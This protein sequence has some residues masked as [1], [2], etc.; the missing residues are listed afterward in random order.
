MHNAS[1]PVSLP[2]DIPMAVFQM[3]PNEAVLWIGCTPP[4][5]KYYS[6]RS[7][8]ASR[9]VPT[10]MFIFGSLGDSVNFLLANTS[11]GGVGNGTGANVFDSLTAVISTPDA[12]TRDAIREAIV[13]GGMPSDAINTDVIP[14]SIL[15]MGHSKLHDTFQMLYRVAL[16]E[17]TTLGDQ[18]INATWPIFMITPP[19]NLTLNPF[20]MPTLR[21]HGTGHGEQ[22]YSQQF[23]QLQERL[24]VV[25]QMSGN[26]LVGKYVS[27]NV[28]IDGFNC[29]A[30]NTFCAG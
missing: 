4:P 11:R 26:T 23:A 14:S 1:T 3:D 6:F 5:L 8:I 30:T 13:S 29:I 22:I 10:P 19:S 2:P 12:N 28:P 15:Q 27:I 20:P 24:T 9:S 21:P 18:Y 7:Y 25:M 17:N 16:F